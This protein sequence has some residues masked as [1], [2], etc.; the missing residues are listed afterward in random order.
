MEKV[1]KNLS[2]HLSKV[3]ECVSRINDFDGKI[4]QIEIDLLLDE[5][6]KMYDE[7]Y[8]LSSFTPALPEEPATEP[9]AGMPTEE[10]ES[11]E[12]SPLFVDT[13]K[14]PVY[15]T[16]EPEPESAEPMAEQPSLDEI[17]G[18]PNDSLFSET[19]EEA[20]LHEEPEPIV[21]AVP[22]PEPEPEPVP[23]PVV[24]KEPTPAEI[25]ATV[26]KPVAEQAAASQPQTLWEKL[27]A[28][29]SASTLGEK[30]AVG[31]TIS[32][33]LN[34]KAGVTTD[35]APTHVDIP[36]PEPQPEPIPE[37]QPKPIP[38]PQ[39]EPSAKEP[40]QHTEHQ[41][42][43]FDYFKK[44][45]ADNTTTQTLGD[46]LGRNFTSGI[47]QKMGANKVDD[48]RTVININDKFT[49]MNELFHNNMKGYNDFILHLNS[50][51]NRDEAL[52]YV[53]V[54]AN[55]YNWDNESAAVKTFYSVFDRKF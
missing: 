37:P 4:P 42:S 27:Q 47:E 29:T 32:D 7:A 3:S 23:E 40:E 46:T 30:I 45:A 11:P 50:M 25:A 28:N 9:A 19:V 1:S 48:L 22:E 43:L 33:L 53:H 13:D 54:V 8:S 5:L 49:F 18:Q 41:S 16:E 10:K 6:R 26:E 12:M 39:P 44:P 21:E 55:Q 15:A 51:T 17:E 2:T 35:T 14:S 31:K 52:A 24:V 20:P 34:E 36:Q 38:E